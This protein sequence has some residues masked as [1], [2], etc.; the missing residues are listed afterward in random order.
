MLPAS[1]GTRLHPSPPPLSWPGNGGCGVSGDSA[2]PHCCRAVRAVNHS[3][4]HRPVGLFCSL[5]KPEFESRT[6]IPPPP[7]QCHPPHTRIYHLQA[8]PRYLPAL[9]FTFLIQEMGFLLNSTYCRRLLGGLNEMLYIRG[10]QPPAMDQ[11]LLVA[12]YEPGRIAGKW[13]A[14]NQAA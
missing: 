11:Y 6:A 13:W 14:T 9:D 1:P 12:C 3:F 2:W 7:P 5:D 4:I 10:P 8:R